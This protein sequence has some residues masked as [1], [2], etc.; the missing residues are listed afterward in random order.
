[1]K[2]SHLLPKSRANFDAPHLATRASLG[3]MIP[4]PK[5]TSIN[6]ASFNVI[7]K[8]N[9]LSGSTSS[10][11]LCLWVRTLDHIRMGSIFNSL[12]VAHA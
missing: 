2:Y 4:I 8:N 3:A 10:P 7:P 9:I 5:G 1:M 11:C 12:E 6:T